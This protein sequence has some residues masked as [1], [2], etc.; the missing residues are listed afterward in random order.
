MTS[1]TLAR[2]YQ[3]SFEHHPYGTLAIT[4]GALNA[5]GDIIAQM[6]EKFSGPQ[7]RHWQY[8]V[9]R[10]F[11][12][13]AFGVGMGPLIGRWNFFLERHFPLRFQSSAL[14]SNTERVSMRALSKRVGADQ[15]IMAPIG[16]SIFIGSMGIMEG[17]DG[18]HIQRKYTDLL[19][20]VLITN[21]KVWPIAQLINFRYMPLPYR[22]PFQSTCG[23][24]WTLYL[25]ILNSKESEVQQREDA[26]RKTLH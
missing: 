9:L 21:W 22:V 3:Q 2:A 25:S 17:R 15:L 13:F 19:V 12:F 14:A 23:I 4:N 20:P 6:T 7:R 18:P 16:L 26:F 11:R 10:T 5:L 1:I 24:F 8:D